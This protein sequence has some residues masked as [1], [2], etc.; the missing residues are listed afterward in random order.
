MALGEKTL[1]G[2]PFAA[3]FKANANAL[4]EL[5][6]RQSVSNT[7]SRWA[8]FKHAGWM[9]F[10]AVLP[11]LGRTV[12]IA[13]WIWQVMDQLE[14]LHD[15]HE[16]NDKQA[17]W[18]AFADLLLNLGMAITLH[19]ATQ[20]ASGKRLADKESEVETSTNEETVVVNVSVKQLANSN[21]FEVSSLQQTLNIT[22]AVNGTPTRLAQVLDRFKMTRPEGL[23]TANTESDT[24]R[25][26][27]GLNQK[28]YA[29]VGKNWYEV[30][31]DD[32]GT[33]MIID[34]SQPTRTGPILINNNRGEWF[35]DTRLRLRGGGSKS[36]IKVAESESAIK[37]RELRTKLTAFESRKAATQAEL[38]QAR[39][40][41]SEASPQTAETARLLYLQ[42]LETQQADYAEALE[43]LK[44]L[45]VFSPT[46]D[47]QQKSLGYLKAQLELIH[48]GIREALTTFTPKMRSVLNQIERQTEAPQNRHIQDARQMSEMIQDMISRLDNI[49]SRGREL[50]GLEKEGLRLLQQ[51]RQLLPA[52]AVDDLK[53]L[54]ITMARN[55]CLPEHTVAT[56]AD[57]W[58]TLDKIVDT[59]DMVVQ[60][61]R[62]TLEERSVSRL[63]ERIDTLNSLIEQF[64]VIDERL[65]DFNS[66]HAEQVVQ[67]T[68][69]RLRK[70]LD[71]FKNRAASNLVQVVEERDAVRARPSRPQLPPR[72]KK[73][74][75]R[76]RFNGVLIGEPRLN[77]QGLETDLVDIR[78]PLT[79]KIIATFHRKN[80]DIWTQ[81]FEA[82]P[83][84][85]AA[86][87][88]QTSVNE[89]Q[90]L[91][92]ALPAFNTRMADQ[93]KQP[94]RSPGGIEYLFHQHAEQL[95]RASSAIEQA[96]TDSNDTES[97][98]SPAATVN[99]ALTAAAQDLYQQATSN[100]LKMTREQP[101]TLSGIEWLKNQQAISIE[102]TITRRRLKGGKTRYLDEYTIRDK[103]SREV[104]WYAHFL[105]STSWVPAK[106]FIHARLKTPQEQ[107]LGL[108]ADT[109]Q[110]L[111]RSQRLAYY[112]SMIG[113]EQAQQLFFN[114]GTEN[115]GCEVC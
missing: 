28:W 41:M 94:G 72:P 54:Q 62:D 55:L 78:A 75:I 104:L 16:Q 35:I 74:F 98:T 33:V 80:S 7:E 111:S 88:L 69:K 105:Y 57:A 85:V 18:A 23:G 107:S 114:A 38:Q 37:A 61:L 24:Y 115:R 66:T 32:S 3:L 21:T 15:A 109:P 91:L 6:D 45:H 79:D 48:A 59:A 36:L 14:Q 86:P 44:T 26:L 113:P 20:G 70:H 71:E 99:K 73:K 95:E 49:E 106:A 51:T 30:S 27:Y 29:P 84:K 2:D 13:A 17:Q 60:V 110:G 82:A 65:L 100:M 47:Y 83:T 1:E 4:S 42:T 58:S 12:G 9:I 101:P 56:M 50:R 52:Y 103:Q 77:E 31:V 89:G 25:H 46:A 97:S 76:T 112:R 10:N 43:H 87:D 64:S 63:D 81:H 108:G 92:D 34:S 39:R 90:T 19:I 5:A 40:A 53:V 96:L 11:F 102:K 68:M 8:S 93:V 22:G 67:A